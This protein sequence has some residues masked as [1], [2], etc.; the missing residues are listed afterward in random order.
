VTKVKFLVNDKD[1]RKTK[2]V[3]VEWVDSYATRGWTH[4]SAFTDVETGNIVSIG[5]LVRESASEITITSSVSTN[6]NVMD[7]LTIPKCAITKRRTL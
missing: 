4:K 6:G 2:K 5:F 7:P 1:I 3:L